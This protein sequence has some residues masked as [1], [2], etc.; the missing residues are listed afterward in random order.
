M[1]DRE[2]LADLITER[3]SV[4][5]LRIAWSNRLAA[6]MRGDAEA[7]KRK[8][9][10]VQRYFEH[11][12]ARE[13]LVDADIAEFVQAFPMY[14]QVTAVRGIGPSFCAKLVAW[15]D[16]HRAGTVSSLWRYAGFGVG[17]YWQNEEGSVV[18]PVQGMR[19]MTSKQLRNWKAL[20]AASDG[21][22]PWEC[23]KQ[24]GGLLNE[25]LLVRDDKALVRIEVCPD[26][27]WEK[28]HIRD[29][30]ISG[31]LSPYNGSLKTLCWKVG[32]SFMRCRSPYRR[33][34]DRYRERYDTARDWTKGHCDMAAK[35]AMVKMFLSHYWERARQVAGLAIRAP[36]VAE[37]LG[38]TDIERPEK[39]GWPEWTG[40]TIR[41]EG[42]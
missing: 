26:E 41:Y 22:V 18:A 4:Q 9:T 38:H 32:T 3:D 37:Y 2:F 39:Y 17:D 1:E 8:L 23:R 15:I 30:R 28:V 13:E 24:A 27:A 6:I 12:Q 34:Y 31:W 5:D 11:Y 36:Y 20:A 33:V 10:L 19:W 14:E 29:R 42:P 25:I 40:E 35:R 7:G 16:P 21:S